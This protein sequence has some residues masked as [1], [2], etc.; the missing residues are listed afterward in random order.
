M[1]SAVLRPW[2]LWGAIS[3][4]VPRFAQK[5]ACPPQPRPLRACLDMGCFSPRPSSRL[6]LAGTLGW[7]GGRGMPCDFNLW[8][9]DLP[10]PVPCSPPSPGSHLSFR[11][12]ARPPWRAPPL[13]SCPLA[14][15]PAHTLLLF[16]PLPGLI[17]SVSPG[18]DP[19]LTY[20]LLVLRP[21]EP[22][23]KTTT[24]LVSDPL[25]QASGLPSMTPGRNWALA[26]TPIPPPRLRPRLL[27]VWQPHRLPAMGS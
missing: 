23:L 19:G 7:G 24:I 20:W 25:F 8:L 12:S 9:R 18:P 22:A 4:Q 16:I 1:R 26:T 14:E 27:A 17:P 10:L 21:N 15:T 6:P 5:A 11:S 13:G 3:Q 2:G